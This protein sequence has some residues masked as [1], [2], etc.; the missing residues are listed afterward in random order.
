MHGGGGGGV[1]VPPPKVGG[2][3]TGTDSTMISIIRPNNSA[4]QTNNISILF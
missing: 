2:G 1:E 3:G 4:L